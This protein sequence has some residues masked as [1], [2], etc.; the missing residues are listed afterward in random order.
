MKKFIGLGFL[1]LV[2]V[3]IMTFIGSNESVQAQPDYY[4]IKVEYAV[5]DSGTWD[6]ST[7]FNCS[8]THTM[9]AVNL[10]RQHD[11]CFYIY[12]PANDSDVVIKYQTSP[13]NSTWYDGLVSID[14]LN[15]NYQVIDPTELTIMWMR[16]VVT[17]TLSLSA[18]TI[19]PQ[20][21]IVSKRH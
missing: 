16:F 14:S 3:Y 7:V 2:A 5:D 9:D 11:V 13:D 21:A 8:T 17:D 18:S 10:E 1:F 12:S 19:S 6:G 4:S 20:I 15:A